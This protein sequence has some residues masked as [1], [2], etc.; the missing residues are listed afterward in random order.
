MMKNNTSETTNQKHPKA[1]PF[2]ISLLWTWQACCLILTSLLPA[3]MLFAQQWQPITQALPTPHFVAEDI[4]RSVSLYG[5][6][7]LVGA[8]DDQGIGAAYLFHKEENSWKWVAKLTA[9][10]AA[11]GDDFGI[12]VSLY[13]G[14]ALIG[15]IHS[16]GNQG[17]SGAAYLFEKPE[18]GW[19][20]TTE[21]AKLTASDGANND[22]FGISVSL[23]DN[24]AL[25]GAPNHTH[26]NVLYAGATYLFEKPLNGWE[27]T[28][29]TTKLTALNV[30]HDDHFGTS[31]SLY[32]DYAL[33]GAPNDCYN[34]AAS[35][36]YLFEKPINGWI[37]A[38]ETAKLTASDGVSSCNQFGISVSFYG[39]YALVGAHQNNGSGSAY[40]FE[41]PLNGWENAT[42][43]AKLIASD[44]VSGDEF[45]ISV[46]FYDDY[47][48]IGADNDDDDGGNSGSGYLFE[49]P[50]QGWVSM[51]ETLKITSSYGTAEDRFG[52]SVELS[53]NYMLVGAVDNNMNKDGRESS[54]YLFEKPVEGWISEYPQEQGIQERTLI[55]TVHTDIASALNHFGKSVSLHGDY[56]L[57][58]APYDDQ[59]G[60][61]AGMAYIV[62][63]YEGAWHK[64]AELTAS[65]GAS[66]D[67]FGHS[68]ALYDNYAL[69][70]AH[71]ND[72]IAD[73]AGAAYLFVKPNGGWTNMTQTAKLTASDGA[74]Y[75]AFGSAVA[76]Y[77]DYALVGAPDDDDLGDGSGSVYLFEKPGNG[78]INATE[79]AK[80]TATDGAPGDAFGQ[81]VSMYGDYVLAGAYN[82]D[83]LGDDSG[84]V[85]LFEKPGNGWVNATETAKLTASDGAAGD[86]F[87][88]S[89]SVY[90]DYVMAG[91]PNDDDLGENSGS[92]YF[93]EKPV[94][95]WINA[96]E[97]AKLTAANGIAGDAFGH[98][99]SG[100]GDSVLVGAY[101]HGG[102]NT[103][104]AYLFEKTDTGW[105]ATTFTADNGQP[106]DAFGSAVSLHG[107]NIIA[108]APGHDDPAPD[109]GSAY[110]FRRYVPL[111]ISSM[112][113]DPTSLGSIPIQF[114]FEEDMTGFEIEDIAVDNGEIFSLQPAG[115][116]VYNA[117]LIPDSSMA[118][119]I[120]EVPASRA[121]GA[122]S[123]ADNAYAIF[124]I[125][126]DGI[127][128]GAVLSG[129]A[130]TVTYYPNVLL[131]VTFSE[132]VQG[133]EAGNLVLTNA[134]LRSIGRI[135]DELYLIDLEAVKEGEVTAFIAPGMVHDIA[136]NGNIAIEPYSFQF[137]RE[138]ENN[139]IAEEQ[140][141]IAGQAPA[142]LTGTAPNGPATLTYRWQHIQ[143]EN[144]WTT[145][146]MAMAQHFTPPLLTAT[147][148]YRRIVQGAPG[149]D[150]D[151]SN[152]LGLCLFPESN[153]IG[154]NQVIDQNDPMA[155]T[156]NEPAPGMVYQ[157]QDSVAEKSWQSIPGATEANYTPL[158]RTRNTW[159]RRK[160]TL[161]ECS[162]FS[163]I[164][165]LCVA[166]G[167]NTI[168]GENEYIVSGNA[169]ETLQG[170]KPTP[171]GTAFRYQWQKSAE[172]G[173]WKY[174]F[175]A[176]GKNYNPPALSATTEYR[177]I[178]HSSCHR[179]TSNVVEII[180]D[181]SPIVDFTGPENSCQGSEIVFQNNTTIPVGAI[182]SY[183]W[184]FGDGSPASAEK[185]PT[186][187][188]YTAG[189]FTITLTAFPE[190][191][192]SGSIARSINVLPLPDA[193][194]GEDVTLLQGQSTPLQSSGGQDYRWRP[195]TGLDN[196]DVANPT[197][198]PPNTTIYAVTVTDAFQC[199][200]NDSVTVTVVENRL[201]VQNLLTPG[202][203]GKNDAWQIQNLGLFG[204]NEIKIFNRWGEEVFTVENY[205][206]NWSG[207]HTNGKKLIDGVYYY[208]IDLKER[209]NIYKG[210]LTIM[211]DK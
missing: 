87:G 76:L 104:A 75:D 178:V 144:T 13:G 119:V 3:S 38:T 74:A 201:I 194:A 49:K 60:H 98:S 162:A 9:S 89:V 173:T 58:G 210:A 14:Y 67:A 114:T 15:A 34:N 64:V 48:L 70:G 10:D 28:T 51:H 160:A 12:S 36:A 121:S 166:I 164:A 31:V 134:T 24:Y 125:A 140:F 5:D 8:S 103:G 108:G 132:P 192:T 71:G 77:Q 81:S 23:Y 182:E 92:A 16:D 29:E 115:E 133:L 175:E 93:F 159:F 139:S 154:P 107:D 11:P 206:N 100:Y 18:G 174:I 113:T 205:Q 136:G 69:V 168:A 189:T 130:D 165:T 148:F 111:D 80:L 32:G 188:Y 39:D 37:N 72:V 156:G 116:G 30:A 131:T 138:I 153:T 4:G 56:A 43:T 143:D 90:G 50:M 195:I 158:P 193:A 25:V 91:T 198:S 196:P 135:T 200:A 27:N 197:A 62:L 181:P 202:G 204:T 185:E 19:I 6:Y 142:R 68:V 179:D 126:Y 157:W 112:A 82:D 152:V 78:W 54:A 109:A 129:N 35:S 21:N 102:N 106:D 17:N 55:S 66:Y 1:K 96:T 146:D 63:Y 41:K 163:N 183:L 94:N 95:G 171:V 57:V 33:V 170:S 20:N 117:L 180:V 97:T 211:R 46:S 53:D 141:L 61:D 122:A 186:H 124:T 83:D 155:F 26:N 42:E 199:Q 167:N 86:A 187:T 137:C 161:G 127:P 65:D 169:P 147:T 176:E 45:G 7:A 191:G 209:N 190:R 120:I 150:I 40:L 88:Y 99:V 118:Q 172:G 145:I 177:R 101:G 105:V 79:T 73:N 85:Y 2:F 149:C 203:N 151:T 59:E 22:Y 52:Y 47:A 207:L 110:F 84:S 208:V 128:P 184:D 44:G 123:G